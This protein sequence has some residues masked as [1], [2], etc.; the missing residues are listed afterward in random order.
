MH[1]DHFAGMIEGMIKFNN[2]IV[3]DFSEKTETKRCYPKKVIKYFL[4]SIHHQV[5]FFR[6][7]SVKNIN[8]L[9]FEETEDLSQLEFLLLLDFLTSEGRQDSEIEQDMAARLCDDLKNAK[10]D[11]IT[12]LMIV[13]FMT[14]FDSNNLGYDDFVNQDRFYSLYCIN[15]NI[16][17]FTINV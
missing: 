1:S 4:D 10:L 5:R 12:K 16:F 13:L 2:S 17:Y 3:F 15:Y 8:V 6:R 14:H 9:Y 11:I 7:M